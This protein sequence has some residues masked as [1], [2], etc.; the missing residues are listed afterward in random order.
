[1]FL[2]LD[3][4]AVPH[5]QN[6]LQYAVAPGPIILASTTN[7]MDQINLSSF[8]FFNLFS[9]GSPIV[10]FSLSSRGRDKCYFHK[11]YKGGTLFEARAKFLSKQKPKHATLST[12]WT[13]TTQKTY[14]V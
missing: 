11:V 6:W 12:T 3:K 4:M 1:M 9:S 8:S 14:A 5:R 2:D 13:I 7:I 10:I